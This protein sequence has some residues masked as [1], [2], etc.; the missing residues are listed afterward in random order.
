MI[1]KFMKPL[2]VL[3]VIFSTLLCCF[4]A[5]Y[6]V[7]VKNSSM[8]NSAL[9]VT[10]FKQIDLEKD[11]DYDSEYFKTD[12]KDAASLKV[13]SEE[14][15][16]EVEG[17]GL[18]MLKNNGALPL[19]ENASISCFAQGSVSLNYSASG[20]G[21]A[22]G[23]SYATLKD[24]LLSKDFWVNETLWNW[25][26]SNK[27]KR[28]YSTA[29][30]VKTY[31]VNEAP[32]EK[33]SEAGG[34][35][36]AEYGDAA[37]VTLS[38][39]SGE[40][41]DVSVKGSDG[42][43]GSYL[44]V[45]PQEEELLIGLTELKTDNVFDRIIVLLNSAV[46][47]ELDFMF[48]DR[49]DIDACLWIGN[50]GMSGIYGV[51]DV[52]A[53]DVNPSGR[54]SDTYCRD[55]FSSPAMTS[56][57]YNENG[58]FARKYADP[59]GF[60]LNSTQ[61]Y[62]GVYTEGIYVGYRYYETRY[63]DFVLGRDKTG[64]FDY[65]AQVAFPFG[66][67]ESFTSFEYEG[68]NVTE[69]GE[70]AYSVSVTVKNTGPED[71]KEV[72]Q[73]Y[74]QKPYDPSDGVEKS[75]VELVGFAKTGMLS[76]R[77][78]SETVTIT[79]DKEVFKS[80]DANN[81]GT[82]ILS[83]GDYYLTVGRNA[84]DALNN[85]LAKK[86]YSPSNT[87]NKMT[88]AG[89]PDFAEKVLEL[90][91]KDAKTYAVSSE[92]GNVIGNQF[93]F[94][95]INRY[96]HRG[97]NGVKYVSRSDW[98]GTWPS[99]KTELAISGSEMF[100]D[101]SSHKSISDDGS[102]SPVYAEQSGLRL[103]MLR[104]LPYESVVW[105]KFLD[106]MTYEE[107][108]LLLTNAAFGTSVIKE[109]GIPPTKANDGPT[110][111]KLSVT[112]TSFPSQGIWAS[113]F[114]IGLVEKIG[115]ILAEDALLSDIDTMYAPGINIHRTP[116]GGRAHEYFSED[117]FLSGMAAI[118]EVKGMQ[119]KGV[120]AVLKHFAFNDA[121]AARNGISV[122]LNEQSAREIYLLPFEYAMRP[123]MGNAVGA[124]SGFNRAGVIWTGASR[125]LQINVSRNEWDFEGYFITD[126]ASA[127][128]A[129]YM[130]YDDGIYNGTD[131]FL[132]SGSKSALAEWR[133]SNAFR[134]RVREAAHRV[135]YVTANHCARMNGITPTSIIVE[136]MPWWQ[137]TIITLI[138]VFAVLSAA[139]LGFWIVILIKSFADKNIVDTES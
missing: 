63:E 89:N 18:V 88:A 52:L 71:G 8:I 124:M 84:H 37:I 42:E 6:D 19:P 41:F 117:P 3:F 10:T 83:A 138:V 28:D 69:S 32:W 116:F 61:E 43:D 34:S 11:D 31:K 134:N 57:A 75:A 128:G 98:E 26:D 119:K 20:S 91:T 66:Y 118:A 79:V 47:M 82:Y 38:R 72:V 74:L 22:D 35:T 13:R 12:Y 30:L 104:G 17:E 64:D 23:S 85:I 86:D 40:G 93:D 108:A 105:N 100:A 48:R 96:E 101:L 112:N 106:Q 16:R 14:L 21:A 133:N 4:I 135:L 68:F 46:P 62:Y 15:C 81:E 103:V 114:N 137:A 123:S 109:H 39:D 44:S 2:T 132:G 67:G 76:A 1:K 9:N 27:Y 131:L 59:Q 7:A 49:I 45:T 92:T 56:W 120:V 136:I 97:P 33:V 110:G 51:A 107:Q 99:G 36:F 50:L 94:A 111:V 78:G 70:N 102:A 5:G 25:Y 73:I 80:Y 55:N 126:M 122:W 29:G 129:L 121:E 87:G 54:L 95:D 113:S 139:C 65:S 77:T 90:K 130:T 58:L 125:A 53:G 60:G 115:D 24:A 127:N